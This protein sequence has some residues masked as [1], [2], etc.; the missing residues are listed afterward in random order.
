M[1]LSEN[2]EAVNSVAERV[3]VT[4]AVACLLVDR[5]KPVVTTAFCPSLMACA[6][7]SRACPDGT[8]AHRPVARADQ[9]V[10]MVIYQGQ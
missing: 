4:C 5:V 3:S 1:I 6:T 9:A 10:L 2:S 7:R 8:A